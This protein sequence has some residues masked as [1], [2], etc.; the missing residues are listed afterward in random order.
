MSRLAL[1]GLDGAPPELVFQRWIDDLPNIKSVMDDGLHR[2][3][4]S[5]TPPVTIPAW[6]SMVT[7]QDPGQLGL[8]EFDG[9]GS[10]EY[11]SMTALDSTDVRGKTIW[12]HLSRLRLNSLVMGVPQTWPPKPMKGVLVSGILTPNKSV[13]WTHPREAA[14]EVDNVARGDYVIDTKDYRTDARDWLIEQI[15]DMTRRRFEAFRYY[16]Q[17]KEFD[18]M[19]LGEV[20]TDRMQRA[21][22]R[23]MDPEHPKFVPDSRHAEA[24]HDYYVFLDEEL[25]NLLDSL[26]QDTSVMIT[27][28]Y[29]A[30]RLE[31]SVCVNEWLIQEKLLKLKKKPEEPGPLTHDMI[32]WKKTKAW[33]TGGNYGRVFLNIEGRETKGTIPEGEADGFRRELKEKLEA[34]AGPSGNSIGTKVLYPEE[35]FT[36]VTGVAPDL[37]VFFGNLGWR[38]A[39]RVGSGELHLEDTEGEHDDTNHDW[40][41]IFIWDHPAKIVP[42]AKDPYSIYDIAPTIMKYFDIDQPKQMIGEPLF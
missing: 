6:T 35:T 19:M 2:R 8:Y 10:R 27:S 30:R 16:A 23:F 31:G 39:G 37:L 34:V 5:T 33:A 42:N 11:D 38:A 17:Q 41:G 13:Q 32:D 9:H 25:G 12:N 21:F 1:I 28:A 22:W 20:G 26:P 7:G 14:G 29:G 24:L 3:L 15:K 36:E 40:E 18:F 4:Q